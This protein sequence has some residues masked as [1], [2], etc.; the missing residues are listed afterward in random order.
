M[1]DYKKFFAPKD[2]LDILM[3]NVLGNGPVDWETVYQNFK[4]RLM[5]ELQASAYKDYE[6][7]TLPLV[8]KE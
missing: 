4:T 1:S 7:I 2:P 6:T 8:D 5:D 3:S